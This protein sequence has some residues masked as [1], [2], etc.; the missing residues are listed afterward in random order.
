M[1]NRF[2]TMYDS[3]VPKIDEMRG[4]INEL[5]QSAKDLGTSSLGVLFL[6]YFSVEV[7]EALALR[8][9]LCLAKL[10]GLSVGWVEVDSAN[11]DAGVNSPKPS[12]GIACFVLND[13]AGGCYAD[14]E[15]IEV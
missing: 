2:K 5:E 11:V 1:Q 15:K 9:G 10:H 12:R 6:E 8:E 4:R 7:C 3:I 13:I 14:E